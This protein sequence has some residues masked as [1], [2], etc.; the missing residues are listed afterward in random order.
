M[1]LAPCNTALLRLANP[2]SQASERFWVDP[3]AV[4]AHPDPLLFA[5]NPNVDVNWSGVLRGLCQL[6]APCC[7]L[8]QL[9]CA[10]V[11]GDNV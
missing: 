8:P 10:V 4:V 3:T 5:V 1:G 11:F 2:R 6:G 7:R 9:F